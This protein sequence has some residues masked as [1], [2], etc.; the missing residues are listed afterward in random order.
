MEVN[1]GNKFDSIEN[2]KINYFIRD[3]FILTFR[4]NN[5][6]TFEIICFS[7]SFTYIYIYIYIVLFSPVK[8]ELGVIPSVHENYSK[9]NI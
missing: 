3:E 5:F 8:P 6:I 7:I 2:R 1:H 4:H 9:M